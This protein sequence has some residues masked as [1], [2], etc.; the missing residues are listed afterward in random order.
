MD[1]CTRDG[2]FVRITAAGIETVLYS[3]GASSTDG[4]DANALVQ[5]MDG[6]FYGTTRGGGANGVGTFFKM[7]PAGVET[8]LYSF[9]TNPTDGFYPDGLIQGTDGNFYGTTYEGGANGNSPTEPPSSC[10]TFF[11]ITPAGVETVLYSFGA[12]AMDGDYPDGLLQGADGDF[13]GTTPT[14]G[15][16]VTANGRGTIFRM[17]PAGVETVLYTFGTSLTDGVAARSLIQGTDGN[18]Y[19]TTYGGGAYGY[20]CVFSTCYGDGTVFKIT[21]AGAKTILYSFG[22]S[23]TDGV[24]PDGMIQGTDGN[25]YGTTSAGGTN[26]SPNSSA[27]AGTVFRV[28]PT[29]LETELYSF[30]AS[31]TDGV[32]PNGLIQAMDGNFY[33]TTSAGGTNHSVPIGDGTFYKIIL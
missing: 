19:G 33:G 28:T 26:P 14:S 30:G 11:R 8:V 29:G 23:S 13:Y 20:Q 32:D 27:G 6:D 1:V 25:F 16:D 31:P 15:G 5:A 4:I 17:T 12:N 7:T 18:F 9:G 10:G 21:P 2:A 22:A 3:F 24:N